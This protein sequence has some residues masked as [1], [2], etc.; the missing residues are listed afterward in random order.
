MRYKLE[1]VLIKGRHASLLHRIVLL[2]SVP[3]CPDC[4]SSHL[5]IALTRRAPELTFLRSC[6]TDLAKAF[7]SPQTQLNLFTK[8]CTG[9]YSTTIRCAAFRLCDQ[10]ALSSC[11]T[12]ICTFLRFR[13]QS[14]LFLSAPIVT[15]RRIDR[16]L[17]TKGNEARHRSGFSANLISHH[18]LAFVQVRS[19]AARR[20]PKSI[21]TSEISSISLRFFH[22]S[23][24]STLIQ[25]TTTLV[26][27]VTR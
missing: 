11:Q 25:S 20:V 7:F 8:I 22:P 21:S 24:P 14:H 4:T 27:Q 9:A 13:R 5:S 1:F 17:E 23:R 10:R 2:R 26:S 12:H 18:S 19:R 15:L 3:Y 6:R 16:T